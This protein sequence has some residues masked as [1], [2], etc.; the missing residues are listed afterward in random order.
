MASYLAREGAILDAL[1]DGTATVEQRTRAAAAFA[2][3]YRTKILS[4][5]WNPD[6]LTNPQLAQVVVWAIKKY[7]K[8][9]TRLHDDAVQTAKTALT[10]AQ[11]TA[12]ADA[13]TDWP[14][15]ALG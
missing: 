8:E 12:A 15:E 4:V 7:V 10:A 1:V 5:G 13:E 2:V 9:I 6:A 14:E 11:A 3:H